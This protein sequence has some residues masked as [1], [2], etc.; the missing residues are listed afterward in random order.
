MKLQEVVTNIVDDVAITL[1]EEFDRNFER[2]AFFDRS[3]PGEKYINN[4]GSQMLR[5]GKLRKSVK[6]TVGNKS[7]SW[8]SSLPY[9]SIQNE[10]GD[11][12]VTAQM[13][14]FFWAMYYKANGA[15]KSGTGGKKRVEKLSR[16][17]SKWKAMALLKVGTK[18]TID[19][20][21]FIGWHP[22]VDRTIEE[23][24]EFNMNE[25]NTYL[26]KKLK[27]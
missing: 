3:W 19:Q 12:E 27:Q 2:K 22:E 20:K 5:S 13:K 23:A 14:R 10:G 18:M 4:K 26:L 17:A 9:A 24:V 15:A 21:Q 25:Y 11:I 1:T 6:H 16:E 7:I 8:S